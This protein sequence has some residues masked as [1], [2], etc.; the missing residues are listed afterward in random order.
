MTTIIKEEDNSK[1]VYFDGRFDTAASM[2]VQKDIQ[3]LINDINSDV[4]LDCENMQYISSSGLR[5]F[6]SILKSVNPTSHHVYIRKL[7]DDLRQVFTVTGF[8]SLFEFL[9]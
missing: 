5:I 4:I 2:Q 6:L 1:V 8:I 9:D 7:R 3:P